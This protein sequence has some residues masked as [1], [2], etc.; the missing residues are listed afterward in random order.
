MFFSAHALRAWTTHAVD[1][2]SD[3]PSMFRAVPAVAVVELRHVA[4]P[5]LSDAQVHGIESDRS[6][7][8]AAAVSFES[9]PVPGAHP[10]PPLASCWSRMYVNAFV[11]AVALA[12]RKASTP[13]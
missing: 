3:G 11:G 1:W 13:Q 5:P 8:M 4:R 12:A 10:N 7:S 9:A 2:L 6:A